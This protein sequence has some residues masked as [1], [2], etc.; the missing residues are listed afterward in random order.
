MCATSWGATL[1]NLGQSSATATDKV[2]SV[3]LSALTSQLQQPW[4]YDIRATRS[5]QLADMKGHHAQLVFYAS[6]LPLS[7]RSKLLWK[8]IS[9]LQVKWSAPLSMSGCLLAVG[10][11]DED[12]DV[13]SAIHLYQPA[14]G[15]W[16][17][18]G[19]LPTPCCDCTCAMIG[20]REMM[21]VAGG[22]PNV[23]IGTV[24]AI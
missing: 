6:A 10:G 20:D 13:V 24:S 1:E 16:V 14:T 15:E 7:E 5:K 9:G 11:R 12:G 19:D 3:S 21:L 18:V 4:F 17:K 23:Y 22:R 8:E 2:F